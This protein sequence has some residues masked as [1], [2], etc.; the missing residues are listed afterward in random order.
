M[1]QILQNILESGIIALIAF[2]IG[3]YIILFGIGSLFT[4]IIMNSFRLQVFNFMKESD[5]Q[6]EQIIQ[7]YTQI[8]SLDTFDISIFF[9]SSVL[10]FISLYFIYIYF[11]RFFLALTKNRKIQAVKMSEVFEILQIKSIYQKEYWIKTSNIKIYIA[12]FDLENSSEEYIFAKV[13]IFNN[14]VFNS[15]AFIKKCLAENRLCVEKI[16]FEKYLTEM[17]E[18]YGDGQENRY[19]DACMLLEEKEAQLL[20][21]Q[22]EVKAL[23]KKSQTLTGRETNAKNNATKGFFIGKIYQEF[24][25]YLLTNNKE[26]SIDDALIKEKLFEFLKSEESIFHILAETKGN[27]NLEEIEAKDIIPSEIIPYIKNELGVF[28]KRR[29]RPKG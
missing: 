24:L 17:S 5:F 20:E 27:K 8:S 22:E 4:Q 23:S 29:G 16:E 9:L 19:K 10:F 13:Y 11:D 14:L 6:E 15:L 21:L 3:L 12:N 7:I 28:A 26:N 2:I 1:K 25:R 18:K